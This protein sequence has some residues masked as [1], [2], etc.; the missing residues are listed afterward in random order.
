LGGAVEHEV[1]VVGVANLHFESRSDG[2]LQEVREVLG[3]EIDISEDQ[4][5]VSK[6]FHLYLRD[7]NPI[8]DADS[9]FAY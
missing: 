9:I 7:F 5:R 4:E 2:G 8:L 3:N 6:R 1:V